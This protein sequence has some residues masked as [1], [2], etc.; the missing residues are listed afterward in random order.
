MT[1][2]R[3]IAETEIGQWNPQDVHVNAAVKRLHS[4]CTIS[5]LNDGHVKDLNLSIDHSTTNSGEPWY[6]RKSQSIDGQPVRKL[7]ASEAKSLD[8]DEVAHL[9]AFLGARNQQAK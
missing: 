2:L 7:I 4:S 9:P 8:F 5:L 6:T 3:D 1:T